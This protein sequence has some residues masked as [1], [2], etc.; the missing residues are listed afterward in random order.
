MK[1]YS[2]SAAGLLMLALTGRTW[3][4]EPKK[5]E[6]PQKV[7]ITVMTSGHFLVSVMLNGKG[8][9]KLIFDTGARRC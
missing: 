9:Y 3:A 2:L 4:E 1:R 5:E 6:L 8:P 7:P